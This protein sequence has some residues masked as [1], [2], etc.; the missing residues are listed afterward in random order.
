MEL[1][2]FQ[3]CCVSSCLPMMDVWPRRAATA[4]QHSS[5][6]SGQ[7]YGGA[8]LRPFRKSDSVQGDPPKSP[9]SPRIFGELPACIG[10]S[11][12]LPALV[13][14][15]AL[16]TLAEVSVK[17]SVALPVN[18]EYYQN[19]PIDLSFP[20]KPAT[21]DLM[22][23]GFQAARPSFTVSAPSGWAEISLSSAS[24]GASHLRI[25]W[26]L[27]ATRE[28]NSYSFSVNAPVR[29]I[30]YATR[31]AA[32]S[33]PIALPDGVKSCCATAAALSTSA[34]SHSSLVGLDLPAGSLLIGWKMHTTS[35]DVS[36]AFDG[37]GE[38]ILQT[39]RE[40][41]ATGIRTHQKAVSGKNSPESLVS[42]DSGLAALIAIRASGIP[43]VDPAWP[44]REYVR[45]GSRVLAFERRASASVTP[46]T[47][48][49]KQGATREFSSN[50]SPLVW[51]QTPTGNPELYG[52]IHPS[53]GLFT[54]PTSIPMELAVTIQARESAGSPVLGTATV[55][56][57]PNSLVVTPSSINL[58]ATGSQPFSANMAA[59]W[60]QAP[61]GSAYGEIDVDTGLYTAPTTVSGTQD[62]TITAQSVG[63]PDMSGTASV[64][65]LPPTG[66]CTA[67]PAT[68]AF[69]PEGGSQSVNLTNCPSGYHWSASSN[70]V[71]WLS[72]VP[73]SGTGNGSITVTASAYSGSQ[74]RDGSILV[75]GT[76]VF[77]EQN[78]SCT[79]SFTSLVIGSPQATIS[80]QVG[81]ESGVG[82][83]SSTGGAGW[84]T[85][86][87]SNGTGQTPVDLVVQNNTGTEVRNANLTI[88]GNGF[89]VAQHPPCT[90]SPSPISL[91]GGSDFQSVELT[92]PTAAPWNAV[93]SQAWLTVAP[94]SGSG[95]AIIT[96][97]ATPNPS[98][99]SRAAIVTIDGK[100][101]S[102]TQSTASVVTLSETSVHLHQPGATHQFY[103]FIDGSPHPAS[104]DWAILAGPGSINGS[105]GLYQ[106]PGTV[107]PE[108]ASAT[109][110]A[111][112]SLGGGSAQATVTLTPYD[113]PSGI[114][115]APQSG[116]GLDQTFIFSVGTSSGVTLVELNALIGPTISQY[117]GACS[118]LVIPST[119]MGHEIRVLA[120]S[121]SAFSLPVYAGQ[122]G[123]VENSQCRVLAAGSSVSV[124]GS[125]TLVQLQVQFKPG[126]IGQMV[127]GASTKNSTNYESEMAAVGSW[128]LSGNVTA[129]PPSAAFSAPAA[130]ATVSGDVVIS[131]WALDNVAQIENAITNV[132]MQVDGVPQP[133][134][135]SMNQASTICATYPNRTGCP[136]VGWSY[137][138]DSRL[139]ANGSRVI[140]IVVTD[141]DHPPKT[142]E[143][144]R[145]VT[146]DNA[147]SVPIT[148]QP[149]SLFAR[150]V[151]SGGYNPSYPQFTAYRGPD[152]LSSVLWS[153]SP[154]FSTS[155]SINTSGVYT[156]A[157]VGYHSPGTQIQVTATNPSD[158]TDKG[159]GYALLEGILGGGAQ[160]IGLTP[161][162][163]V[164]F[165]TSL[166]SVT[167]SVSPSLGTIT[168]YG[169]FT[170]NASGHAPGTI[171]K[172]TASQVGNSNNRE[173]AYVQLW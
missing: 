144:T 128:D 107:A 87:P 26:K 105:T 16:P 25:F 173:S 79:S 137:T 126:F 160:L 103:A 32:P 28:S 71:A 158:S 102:V 45:L 11:M 7:A 153:L 91:R 84:L 42:D 81:C 109:I 129:Q 125:T 113:P 116:S 80:G 110:Q 58:Q 19:V 104:V 155:G 14:L 141:G 114:G 5:S 171:V 89:T 50:L 63:N 78:P 95:G 18:G 54:A 36:D 57:E 148:V 154:P 60:S 112:D 134:L 143:I 86:Q 44:T 2:E 27:A 140:K 31:G 127:T 65:L 37:L 30:G 162:Q 4:P 169:L 43:A 90:F 48:R 21:G 150:M 20:E 35:A 168:N 156:P 70:G 139:V 133:G 106:A 62:V 136:N 13:L 67:S 68:L 108:N 6:D 3:I 124:S 170:H 92:C 1:N 123:F 117:E 163:Q 159:N 119:P 85:F 161:G 12:R 164:Q 146:V 17:Q 121:G 39:G 130:G 34:G 56:L 33:E 51:T 49:L 151:V 131:G 99:S 61:V 23:F 52:E 96:L 24:S 111:H 8:D 41:S 120:N 73:P 138:W 83:T 147:P 101:I 76:S 88:A 118:I 93:S 40:F 46:A 66:G 98:G 82:W 38:V 135:V 69:G 142:T 10:P 122:A 53:T 9:P 172:I 165:M 97:S 22:L 145:T 72:V 152:V 167:Y 55:I 74:V 77:V 132:Q 47:V 15:L 59:T 157:P 115:V 94:Q 64:I 100:Q 149:G 29:V 166:G 75:D